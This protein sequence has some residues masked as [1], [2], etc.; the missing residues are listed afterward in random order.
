[1]LRKKNIRFT[2]N[3]LIMFSK[4]S[5]IGAC[6][7]K[8]VADYGVA[9]K[10]EYCLLFSSPMW[11]CL[12]TRSEGRDYSPVIPHALYY[13][14]PHFLEFFSVNANCL[15]LPVRSSSKADFD[16]VAKRSGLN[17]KVLAK[18]SGD[19]LYPLAA[20]DFSQS[21]SIPVVIE[22]I[23]VSAGAGNAV[24]QLFFSETTSCTM[25]QKEFMRY[26]YNETNEKINTDWYIMLPSQTKLSDELLRRKVNAALTRQYYNLKP[27]SRGFLTGTDVITF[28]RSSLKN[29]TGSYSSPEAHELLWQQCQPM[30]ALRSDYSRALNLFSSICDKP[31]ISD[32][33]LATAENAL[34]W[35]DFLTKITKGAGG[36]EFF[37]EQYRKMEVAEKNFLNYFE[38]AI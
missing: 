6:L 9:L 19:I 35:D 34:I 18:V 29:G 8:V 20:N 30:A 22:S 23:D 16:Y 36:A 4:Y 12:D 5:D 31:A 15:F 3:I 11:L 33:Q 37:I 14:H 26:W 38:K 21:V 27:A 2:L 28:L 7:S 24:L 1:M 10:P 25:G 17:K 13:F 32:L